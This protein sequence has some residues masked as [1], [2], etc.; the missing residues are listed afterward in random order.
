[1]VDVT[2]QPSG[3]RDCASVSSLIRLVDN[4]LSSYVSSRALSFCVFGVAVDQCHRL[5]SSVVLYMYWRACSHDCIRG[6]LF[7]RYTVLT[8]RGTSSVFEVCRH[9]CP[10]LSRAAE[11]A[12]MTL[13]SVFFSRC[14]VMTAHVLRVHLIFAMLDFCSN[15]EV[16]KKVI[17]C[18]ITK[19]YYHG[20]C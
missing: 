19:N 7:S 16:A 10:L 4:R 13:H 17:F 15:K 6:I 2:S 1:M 11:G 3:R 8:T 14:A 20:T 5:T 9:H 18:A 12:E